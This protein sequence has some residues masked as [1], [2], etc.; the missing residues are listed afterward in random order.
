[1][2]EKYNIRNLSKYYREIFCGNYQMSESTILA[3][4]LSFGGGF[5]DSYSYTVRGGVF[6]NAQTGNLVLLSQSF[7]NFDMYL[8][9]K[10]SIPIL[11]FV[12]GVYVTN[13]IEQRFKYRNLVHW[14]QI[15]VFVEAI[16]L[17]FVSF[18]P[19]EYNNL[20]NTIISFVCAIQ[21]EAFR[22]F[23]NI[24]LAT[25]MCTGNLRIGTEILAKSRYKNSIE[26]NSDLKKS[27][28]YYFIVFIFCFGAGIGSILSS[29]IGI[30]AI[31]FDSIL[32]FISFIIMNIYKYD[33]KNN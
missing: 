12:L 15:V 20:A 5:R 19:V 8:I 28:Y 6:A 30:K 22:K 17:F 23:M 33:L 7:S 27:K 21:V 18:L 29:Y 25:T 24:P 1:M 9:V 31:I 13:L 32:M 2:R 3:I 16:S 10:Y 4:L 11:A 26:K 14:R